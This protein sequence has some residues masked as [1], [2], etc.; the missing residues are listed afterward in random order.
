[1]HRCIE[2]C[3]NLD[4]DLKK[5]LQQTDSTM[6]R[7]KVMDIELSSPIGG[8][9]GLDDH[10]FILVLV[11]L[12]GVPIG[13]VKVPATGGVCSPDLLIKGIIQ[14]HGQ[15]VVSHQLEDCLATTGSG[16]GFELRG[17]SDAVHPVYQGPTPRVTVAVCTRDRTAY[18][19]KC[20]DSLRLLDYPNVD[21]L[22]V[23][24]SPS[25]NDTERLVKERYPDF[26]Y[27]FE[28]RPGLNWARNRAIT[29]ARGEII[30]FTDDDVLVDPGWVKGLVSAFA[31]NPCVMAVTG[32]VVPYELETEA[33]ILFESRGGFG[34]GFV[35]KCFQGDPEAGRQLAT[36]FGD[37]GKFGTGAN[38]AFRKALFDEIGFFD[39]ALDVGTLTH[40]GGD[41]EMFFRVVKHGYALVYE[42]SAM[43]RHRH[44]REYSE[45]RTQLNGWGAGFFS[46]LIRGFLSYPDERLGFIKIVMR[47]LGWHVFRLIKSILTPCE[48]PRDLMVAD[49]NGSLSSLF[50]YRRAQRTAD[51]I[52]ATHGPLV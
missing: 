7:I 39:P 41:L 29:E 45:L 49:L 44:R 25:S 16:R 10:E 22:V 42:P 18:V 32:L 15:A 9:Q 34:R 35:R 31:E 36:I 12:H 43:V 13:Y 21:L 38:M 52:R 4:R 8:I 23:N 24:N 51:N 48:F 6:K 2:Q 40:G 19:G 27:F 17:L 1:M 28:P 33:Q 46:Y 5:V 50:R 3:L 47:T 20:L 11:R 37:T 26:R 30:A 14:S